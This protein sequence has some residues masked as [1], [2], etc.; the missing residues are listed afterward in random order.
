MFLSVHMF[1][2]GLASFWGLQLPP[3]IQRLAALIDARVGMI[4]GDARRKDN[5]EQCGRLLR[6]SEV[7]CFRSWKNPSNQELLGMDGQMDG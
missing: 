4:G 3:A 6:K 1:S 5:E 2:V 7:C